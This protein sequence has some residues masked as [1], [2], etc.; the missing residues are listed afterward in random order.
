MAG[1]AYIMKKGKQP[2]KKGTKLQRNLGVSD[3]EIK[4]AVAV[5]H[6][7]DVNKRKGMKDEPKFTK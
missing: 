4:R 6:T 7:I 5:K 2:P 3:K 1:E